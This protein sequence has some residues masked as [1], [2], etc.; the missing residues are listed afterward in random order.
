MRMNACVCL[1][2][3]MS[4][5]VFVWHTM[6]AGK[7]LKQEVYCSS[8]ADQ[9]PIWHPVWGWGNWL[10]QSSSRWK[11]DRKQNHTGC[12]WGE[13][14]LILHIKLSLPVI[15]QG[16]QLYNVALVEVYQVWGNN[17]DTKIKVLLFCLG[18]TATISEQNLCCKLEMWSTTQNLQAWKV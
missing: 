11:S 2:P 16:K 15:N 13:L 17:D 8:S 3:H 12:L 4:A 10:P 7:R 9:V 1:S 18:G 5:G 14:A 6:K